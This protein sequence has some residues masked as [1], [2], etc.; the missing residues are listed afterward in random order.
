MPRPKRGRKTAG[1]ERE[2]EERKRHTPAGV[3]PIWSGTISFGLVSV[4][5]DVFPAVRASGIAL[6]MLAPDG[7]PLQRRYFCPEHGRDVDYDELVRGYEVDDGSFVLLDDE[8]LEAVA[9]RKSRDIDLRRFVAVDEI[10]PFAFE[11]AYVLTPAGDSTKPYRLLAEVM[12]QEGRAGVATFV[13]RTKEYLVAILARHGVLFAE[14][15]RF[16]GELRTPDD[17]G[18][19]DLAEPDR[20]EVG[21]FVRAIEKLR[22][23][24]IRR[25][26]LGDERLESL[27]E[28]VERKHAAGEDVVEVPEEVEAD[29]PPPDEDDEVPSGDPFEVI[30]SRLTNLSET[31]R[32]HGG[33][34]ATNGHGNGR[35]R[36][37]SDTRAALGE[38]S[39]DALYERAKELDVP[40]RSSMTKDALVKA[41]TKADSKG[42]N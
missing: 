6:R 31:P 19:A 37:R 42:G 17:V 34:G 7:V 33:N 29:A 39:K 10:D 9:P 5:V 11:R 15:L 24:D 25:E 22:K 14:T 38:L 32:K 27:R 3:R 1:R 35:S 16:A 12:E 20:K 36:G 41:I 30:R 13:M 26:E 21:E 40:G 28:L 8:E 4:P 18:L 2:R 23:N